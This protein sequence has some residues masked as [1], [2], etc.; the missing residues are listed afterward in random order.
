[1][2]GSGPGFVPAELVCGG[3]EHT[4]QPLVLSVLQAKL[5]RI[6]VHGMREFVDVRLAREVIRGRSQAAVGTLPQWRVRRVISN[7]RVRNVVVDWQSRR[8]RVV[9]VKFPR[10]NR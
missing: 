4:A 10:G 8:A 6:H 5:E 3:S 7:V 2:I 1:M 9:V